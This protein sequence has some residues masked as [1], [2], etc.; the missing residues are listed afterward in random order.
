MPESFLNGLFAVSIRALCLVALAWLLT[1]G[2]RRASL[3]HAIWMVVLG[4]MLFLPA[5]N[6]IVP[7]MPIPVRLPALAPAAALKSL[8]TIA[9]GNTVRQPSIP[10]ARPD[11]PPTKRRNPYPIP[12]AAYL[13]VTAAFLT[14]LAL[15]YWRVRRLVRASVPISTP[16]LE[17]V[18]VAHS[19]AWPFPDLLE[20]SGVRVPAVAGLREPVVLLPPGWRHWDEWELRAVLAHELAHVRR[21]DWAAALAASV[22]KCLFWFHPLAWWLERR[23]AALAEA[24]C[25]EGAVRITRDPRRYAQ[26]LLAFASRAPFAQSG[27]LAMARASNVE[28]R[29]DRVLNLRLP[30]GPVVSKGAWAL[31]LA[32]GI[33]IL[34]AAA[35]LQLTPPPPVPGAADWEDAYP[36][37]SLI[38]GWAMTPADAQAAESKLAAEPGD[39]A[40]RMKLLSY[41]FQYAMHQPRLRHIFWLI[42]HHPESNVHGGR[43]TGLIARPNPLNSHADYDRGKELWRSQAQIHRDDPRVLGNAAAY[44]READPFEAENLLLQARRLEP[45]NPGWTRRLAILYAGAIG[46]DLAPVSPGIPGR[47]VDA[48]F[49]ARART[50]LETAQEAELA[51]TAGLMLIPIDPGFYED[52]PWKDAFDASA[53]RASAYA[54]LLLERARSLEPENPRWRQPAGVRRFSSPSAASTAALPVISPAYPPLAQHARIQG[55]VRLSITSDREGRVTQV[56]V[57]SGHPLL[58]PAAVE[59]AKQVTTHP[60]SVTQV[61]VPFTLSR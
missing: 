35:A 19:L 48:A 34:C 50:A 20:S 28:R 49:V 22:N 60:D 46:I 21:R 38:E 24:A 15:G 3:N 41:Y 59:A 8:P 43:Q 10:V 2:I 36:M 16:V 45:G 32:C 42:E 33:P 13:A 57:V 29:I 47:P 26:L 39:L 14:R 37:Q 25:D 61:D 18:A 56:K 53:K 55:T 1:L 27:A 4:G 9:A 58:V 23:L 31:L 51:G 17:Q 40:L 5:L 12:L 6:L 44:F 7:P 54:A 52:A 30:A 11:A